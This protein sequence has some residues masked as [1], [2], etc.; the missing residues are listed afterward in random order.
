MKRP[1]ADGADQM[2]EASAAGAAAP[3][4]SVELTLLRQALEAVVDE[5]ALGLMRAA[6]SPNMKSSLDLATGLCDADGELIAQSLTLPVHLGSIPHAVA[7]V[8]AAYPDG[9]APGD[10]FVLNDPYDGG[11]HLPD[12]FLIAPVFTQSSVL[13]PQSCDL[14]GYAVAV[15]H[16]TD[17]G[18]RVAGGNACDS[19]EIYQEGLRLPPLKLYAAGRADEGLFRLIERNVRVP[20]M[21]LGDL[22]A[23][24]AACHIGAQGFRALLERH[25]RARLQAQTR[26]LVAYGE[27]FARAQLAA[28]PEGEYRFEDFLDDDG[29][30]PTPI[31]IR[32]AVTVRGGTLTADFTGS[33]SQVRGAINCPLP[34]TRSVVYAAVRCLLSQDLP[35]N[36]G[37]FRPIRVV[38]P[39]GTIVNPVLPAPVAARGLTGFRIANALFGA[40]AHL[41]PE[42]VP[43]CESG[44]D[45]GVSIGGYD[46]ARRPFVFLEFL[47]ASWG[48]R[49]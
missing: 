7:A 39:E 10:V 8:R 1:S 19:T 34:F 2:L 40:L 17:I 48:G 6:Y 28:L 45:T 47:H 11:T 32:V 12:I 37:Y 23:Q 41:A 21:V 33:A 24:L 30:D 22:R 31:P 38:A 5:M 35:N 4:D 36:G 27:R 13:S 16:H 42:R 25:G 20:R 15:A 18:G 43:A 29:I 44:G 3:M 46:A 14:A 49:P 26:A 9:G